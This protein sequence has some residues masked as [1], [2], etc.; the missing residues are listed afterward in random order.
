LPLPLK[1]LERF[2]T[3]QIKYEKTTVIQHLVLF[4]ESC[5]EYILVFSAFISQPKS[6]TIYSFRQ[7]ASSQGFTNTNSKV[8]RNAQVA[9]HS[10]LFITV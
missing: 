1:K 7:T 2:F 6:S 9:P 4:D 5:T 8:L 3:L 10:T